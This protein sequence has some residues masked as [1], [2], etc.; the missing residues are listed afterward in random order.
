M[1]DKFKLL[2]DYA[3]LEDAVAAVEAL[4]RNCSRDEELRIE[5]VRSHQLQPLKRA[6]GG[7]MAAGGK[8]GGR[9]DKDGNPSKV[10][11]VGF[12]LVCKVDEEELVRAFGPYGEIECVKTFP[13]RT[14]AFVQFKSVREATY[15]KENLEGKLFSDPRVHIQYSKRN[16]ELGD[17]TYGATRINDNVALLASRWMGDAQ[18]HHIENGRGGDHFN[19]PSDSSRMQMGGLRPEYRPNSFGLSLNPSPVSTRNSGRGDGQVDS[20]MGYPQCVS[21]GRTDGR[22]SV[23]SGWDLLD[24]DLQPLKDTKRICLHPREGEEPFGYDSRY[25]SHPQSGKFGGG[26]CKGPGGLGSYESARPLTLE[27]AYG[28]AS[29]RTHRD[30]VSSSN[31]CSSAGSLQTANFGQTQYNK[32]HDEFSADSGTVT[33]GWQWHGT[34]AN[35]GTPVCQAR[36]RPVN[37]GSDVSILGVVNCAA[38]IDIDMLAKYVFQSRDFGL[39]FVAPEGDHDILPYQE[40]VQHLQEKYQA[41]VASLADGTSLFLVPPSKFSEDVLRVPHQNFL[42]GV[43]LKFQHQSSVGCC[44]PF[45][46]HNQVLPVQQQFFSQHQHQKPQESVLFQHFGQHMNQDN[47]LPLQE[48]VGYQGALQTTPT[49]VQQQQAGQAANGSNR[50]SLGNSTKFRFAELANIAGLTTCGLTPE[51]IASLTALLPQHTEMPSGTTASNSA[52]SPVAGELCMSFVSGE[53]SPGQQAPLVGDTAISA[54]PVQNHSRLGYKLPQ[55]NPATTQP[56][57]GGWPLHQHTEQDH[58]QESSTDA[59]QS[60]VPTYGSTFMTSQHQLQYLVQQP[61]Q[62]PRAHQGPQVAPAGPPVL[63]LPASGSKCAP[64]HHAYSWLPQIHQSGFVGCNGQQQYNNL[65][66]A[67]PRVVQEPTVAAPYLPADQLAKLT[68][69]LTTRH[70]QLAQQQPANLLL[71]QHCEQQSQSQPMPSSLPNQQVLVQQQQ[72]ATIQSNSLQLQ[73]ACSHQSQPSNYQQFVQSQWG[74]GSH[75][76]HLQSP[77]ISQPFSELQSQALAQEEENPR[78]VLNSQGSSWD[79]ETSLGNNASDGS[80]HQGGHESNA[81]QRRFE[82]T[83]QL[84]AALLQQM[85]QQQGKLPVDAEQL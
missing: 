27:T 40:F 77:L 83:L 37:K 68:A 49:Q 43:V 21:G 30:T 62:L 35:N 59:M 25:E 55:N 19:R 1:E 75:S 14:Y 45:P 7:I 60:R 5:F 50:E 24:E 9:A 80:E 46:Q 39:V 29:S 20:M 48:P 16:L 73:E 85:Q 58:Q 76:Q 6:G 69:L 26:N 72:E 47:H 82:A 36:C 11:W 2:Q 12:P 67:I 28:M 22:S 4:T 84:A 63:G 23:D 33:E 17:G 31:L 54:T 66:S 38:H 51:L 15:A 56:P 8:S 64:V 18:G 78:V 34:I 61:E 57:Q 70:P 53:I 79:L 81:Q 52:V 10:L 42:L 41:G 32:K 13:G 3:R 65:L 44:F 71:Q 74:Q